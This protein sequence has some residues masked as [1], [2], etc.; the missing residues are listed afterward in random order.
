MNKINL[1]NLLLEKYNEHSDLLKQIENYEKSW[2][3]ILDLIQ[4]SY[5]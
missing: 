3:D 1:N 5:K 4:P 2:S